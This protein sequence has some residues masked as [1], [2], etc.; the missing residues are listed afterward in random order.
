LGKSSLLEALA[1]HR[2]G[3]DFA[4]ANA[5]HVHDRPDEAIYLTAKCGLSAIGWRGIE[6]FQLL[7]VDVI[8]RY[9]GDL[10]PLR[11][12]V[13]ITRVGKAASRGYAISTRDLVPLSKAVRY[14]DKLSRG[15]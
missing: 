14:F 10:F 13:A 6:A 2:Q 4:L 5:Q 9:A 15:S 7:S 8:A 1:I 11:A 12:C 3:H